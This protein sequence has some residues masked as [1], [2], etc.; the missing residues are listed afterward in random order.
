MAAR[1]LSEAERAELEARRAALELELKLLTA[2]LRSDAALR[3][4]RGCST[5]EVSAR[6]AYLRKIYGRG[7]GRV[8]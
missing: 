2:E 3:A 5:V 8:G 6:D 1:R 7:R 4:A